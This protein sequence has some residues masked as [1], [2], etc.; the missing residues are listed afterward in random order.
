MRSDATVLGKKKKKKITFR[1]IPSGMGGHV[2]TREAL[3]LRT[4]SYEGVE[5]RT[6]DVLKETH[7]RTIL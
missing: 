1:N 7:T 4:Q 6:F 2:T 5:E 3:L